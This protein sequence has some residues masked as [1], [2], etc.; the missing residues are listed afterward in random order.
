MDPPP[1]LIPVSMTGAVLLPTEVEFTAGTRRG[2][3][4]RRQ[5]AMER[6]TGAR[7]IVRGDAMR[8]LGDILS[9]LVFVSA[10]GLAAV[11]A[12]V[13]L[14]AWWCR[15]EAVERRKASPDGGSHDAESA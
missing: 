15:C 4:W 9:I 6:R 12:G 1:G 10:L 8:L 14:D 11:A 13:G 7:G 3:W 5:V 2:K